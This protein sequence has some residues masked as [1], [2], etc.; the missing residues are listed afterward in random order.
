[1][2]MAEASRCAAA[3]LHG[4]RTSLSKCFEMPQVAKSLFKAQAALYNTHVHVDALSGLADSWKA[5]SRIWASQTR[6]RAL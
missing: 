1:V 6:Y 3:D 4:S 5:A 2:Q